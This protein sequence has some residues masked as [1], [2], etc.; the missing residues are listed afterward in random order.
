M[1]KTEKLYI[2]AA[3]GERC[4]TPPVWLMRQAGRYLSEYNLVRKKYSFLDICNNPELACEVTLQ[5]IRRFHFDA[6]IMFSDILVPLVPMGAELSFGKGHGPVIANTIRS[7][8]D[9]GR[10]KQIEPRESLSFVLESVKMMRAE[11]PEDVALIAFAGAPFTLS[12]YWIE[13]GKP[14]PFANQKG[15]M[16]HQPEAFTNLLEKLS[17]MAVDYLSALI[18]AGA[19]A[20][21][22][23]D[24]WAGILPANEFRQFNLPI[25][26]SIFRRLKHLDIPMTYYAK[27][28]MHLLPELKNTGAEVISLDWRSPLDGARNI[29]GSEM[30]LQGNLDPTVLLGS[31]ETIRAE[32]RRVLDEVNG[33]GGHI[34][35]LGHGILPM[36]P[37]SSVEILLDEIRGKAA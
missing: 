32:T 3:H 16:Y 26:R 12:S 14:E 18:E 20:I 35:N 2:R 34:F 17:D 33:G 15:L 31:E 5:P 9:V 6:S 36:T 23:F 8:S 27:G 11:L 21:Q 19:D 37:V 30:V 25:L 10:I 7:K 28:S 13:G 24:T 29:L 1:K 4:K 22:L